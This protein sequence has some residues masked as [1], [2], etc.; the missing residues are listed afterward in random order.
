MFSELSTMGIVF[1]ASAWLLV[2]SLT[3][4]CLVKVLKSGN[5]MGEE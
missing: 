3:A 1:V 5:K 4:F 2:S